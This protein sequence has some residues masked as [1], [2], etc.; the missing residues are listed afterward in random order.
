[1]KTTALAR[2][3]VVA[4]AAAALAGCSVINPITSQNHYAPADGV[5]V[6]I[7]SDARGL[8]LLVVTTAKDAP[9]VLTGSI[10]NDGTEELDVT[11]SID[12]VIAAHVKVP[13]DGTVKMGTGEGEALGSGR[14]ARGSRRHRARV[15]RRRGDRRPA[16][17]HPG[18]RRHPSPVPG[19]C[20]LDPAA[21]DRDANAVA[22]RVAVA[23]SVRTPSP[24]HL[25]RRHRPAT[26]RASL[27]RGLQPPISRSG[28]R[29]SPPSPSLTGWRTWC[30]C[31]S[32]R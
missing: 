13:A 22:L 29:C 32:S 23:V 17:R 2:L 3:A 12:G 14:V 25:A 30:G 15:D 8:D 16:V 5:Q 6:A 9:A 27:V 18:R 19:H 4:V 31:R 1:M 26:R 11:I 10:Y 24:R 21:A 7:G 20:G 28:R